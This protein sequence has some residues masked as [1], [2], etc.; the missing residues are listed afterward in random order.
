MYNINKYINVIKQ[1]I[2]NVERCKFN[3]LL[4]LNELNL[5]SSTD[6]DIR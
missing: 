1:T 6:L 2:I 4:N 3:Y 5:Y